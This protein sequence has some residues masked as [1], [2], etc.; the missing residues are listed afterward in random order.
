M[1]GIDFDI[2][3]ETTLQRARIALAAACRSSKRGVSIFNSEML[4]DVEARRDLEA[5][6][7]QAV[8][9]NEFAIVFQ[10]QFDILSGRLVGFEA[11]LRWVHSERG[12]VSPAVFIPLAEDLGLIQR[13]GAWVLRQA[14]SVAGGWPP[15]LS[16]SVNVSPAQ[17]ETGDFEAMVENALNAAKIEP[18]RLE[19]E[20]TEGVL[21]PNDTAIIS[22]ID[23]LRR[24]GVRLALDDFGTGYSS[25]AYLQ[26][27]S[28]DK[29]KID[30]AFVRSAPSKANQ[31]IIRAAIGI[32]EA[33]DMKT[34]AEGVETED[35][36]AL[37]REAGCSQVQ[38]YLTG[39]PM[40][41]E[42]ATRIANSA[43]GQ[44]DL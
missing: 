13:I 35:Q 20:V 37:V 10:P 11:L 2:P 9:L 14:C 21:L 40:S 1:T 22:L 41:A 24:R 33:L 23:R 39:R 19:L 5:D 34:V 30:Q 6:L 43:E 26:R 36:L 32:A 27:Y 38:G 18:G 42:D 17:L 25:L 16:V 44:S 31:A 12:P 8:S 29:L 4:G 3:V 7:R 28:F 15:G